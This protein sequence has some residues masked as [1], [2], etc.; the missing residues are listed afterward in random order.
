[1]L[2][3]VRVRESVLLVEILRVGL[4]HADHVGKEEAGIVG[5]VV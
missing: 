3:L 5:A 4:T 1:M 2:L